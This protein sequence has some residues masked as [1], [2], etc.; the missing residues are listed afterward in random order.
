MPP[1]KHERASRKWSVAASFVHAAENLQSNILGQLVS[2]SVGVTLDARLAAPSSLR[3]GASMNEPRRSRRQGGALT[4]KDVA[5]HAGVS[6]MTVSRVLNADR[7][8][9]A[10]TREHVNASIAELNYAPNPAARSLAGADRIRIGLLYSN[11]SAAYLSEFLVGGLEEVSRSN[12]QLVVEKCEPGQDD[13][14]AATRLVKDGIDGVIL[15]PP[16][17]DSADVIRIFADAHIPAVAV[18]TGRPASS[19]AAVSIDDRAAA[20]A[21]TAH[22]IALGHRRIALIGGNP[23]Q[24]ASE[25]RRLGYRDALAAAGI[26]WDDALVADGLFSYRSGLDAAEALLSLAAPPTAIFAANDDM[27][28]GAVAVAHRRHLDVPRDLTVVGFDDTA[29]AT[30]IWPELTT[31]RQPIAAMSRAAV[32]LLVDD[33]RRA[34]GGETARRTR[35]LLDFTLIRRASDAAPRAR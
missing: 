31:I 26:A 28:A 25:E 2:I 14:D 11:P 8:V 10:S 23:N 20:T 7:N 32:E 6:T 17:C 15:P 3:H 24:T 5:A 9:R 4:I 21:M 27:A 19:V 29:L 35:L 22:L 13:T 12:I 34:R 30:T 16:L 33:I 18:A 1:V